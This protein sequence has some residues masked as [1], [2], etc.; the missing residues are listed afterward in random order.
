VGF[1]TRR[2]D[3]HR[4]AVSV[5]RGS[6]RPVVVTAFPVKAPDR[7]K[8]AQDAPRPTSLRCRFQSVFTASSIPLT[9]VAITSPKHAKALG[10]TWF[11]MRLRT[12]ARWTG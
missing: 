8:L 5:L 4:A 10:S 12:L 7:A 2:R 11:M 1:G 6:R 9:I 3:R